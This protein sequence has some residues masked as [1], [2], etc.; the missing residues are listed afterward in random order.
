MSSKTT[1][2]GLLPM[3]TIAAVI[4]FVLFSCVN[5]GSGTGKGAAA[6]GGLSHVDA[7]TMCQMALKRVSRD[8]DNADIPYVSN[9]GK[10]P[11]FYYAWGPQTKVARMRNGLGLDVAT[12]ASCTVDATTKR[13]T[14]LTLDGKTIL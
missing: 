7:L 13:I 5:E 1:Q 3:L 8:P 9:M 2:I 14:S 6:P 10:G 12:T 4:V 11:E